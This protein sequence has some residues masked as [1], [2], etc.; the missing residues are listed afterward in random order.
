ML[1]VGVTMR[2]FLA[3]G[4][5]LLG[6]RAGLAADAAAAAQEPSGFFGRFV[7]NHLT[8]GARVTYFWLKD[9]RRSGPNGLDNLNQDG[10]FLG[11]LWGL[12]AQQH[13]FPNPFVEY[14]VISG[15]GAGIAYDQ[16]RAKTLDWTDNTA[17]L[18]TAGD[19]DVEIK[20][21]QYYV[22]GRLRNQ[23]RLTPYAN[24]GIARYHAHFFASPDWLTPGRHFEVDDTNGWF[25]SGGCNVAFT[26]HV[27]L[28][29]LYRYSELDAV[30]GRA[31]FNARRH[32]SGAFPMRSDIVGAG[33][34][35]AF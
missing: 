8:I 13:Y 24:V 21:V 3:A 22:F 28:D 25:V 16:A 9:T 4:F 18:V 20:G 33:F 27:G 15:F 11:S 19:G 2:L 6:V 35:V 23:T 30:V 34:V 29:V 7:A 5:V 31:F 12:D 1:F 17:R 32:R 14:R 26:R 10:N